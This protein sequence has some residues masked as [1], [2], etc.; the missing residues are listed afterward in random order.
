MYVR[1]RINQGIDSDA[2]AV[3]QQAVH[4][5]TDGR[6]EVWIV[7]EGDKVMLQPVEVGP[8]V[9]G[10]WVIR[11]GLKPGDRVVAEGFQKIV[12]GT[13]VVPIRSRPPRCRRA[14]PGGRGSAEAGADRRLQGS[15]RRRPRGQFLHRPSGP[16]PGS[17]RSSS[18]SAAR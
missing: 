11:E 17:S 18:A 2:I 12:A 10:V 4:R 6:A 15:L 14:L 3:P 8:V 7:G 5:S 9:D 16:S 1:A 13:R